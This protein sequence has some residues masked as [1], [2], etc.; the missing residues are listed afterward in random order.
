[1]FSLWTYPPGVALSIV[2]CSWNRSDAHAWC[3][4]AIWEVIIAELCLKS[5]GVKGC[6]N[7][8]KPLSSL[9]TASPT[10]ETISGIKTLQVISQTEVPAQHHEEQGGHKSE[11]CWPTV[12]DSK[13]RVWW[14]TACMEEWS[15]ITF[16]PSVQKSIQNLPNTFKTRHSE[17]T[18][19]KQKGKHFV[20]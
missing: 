4:E 14:K 15:R 20:R 9:N 6:L 18:R 17:T 8:T 1:M 11:N 5:S 12:M 16:S 13:E 10:S 7:L 2:F 3:L 19:E